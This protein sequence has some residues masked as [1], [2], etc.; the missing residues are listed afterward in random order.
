MRCEDVRELLGG[1]V[2]QALEPK[3][4]EAVRA[5]LSGCPGCAREWSLLEP[6]P[7]LLE[8]AHDPEVSQAKP[9]AS[10]EEAVLDRFARERPPLRADG[11]DRRGGGERRGRGRGARAL[12]QLGRP[13]PAA[14]LAAVAGAAIALGAGA[15]LDGS[16]D[17]Q[18]KVYG[19][20]LE[21]APATPG[22][23][24][25]YAY[26]RL[27]TFDAGTRVQL[28]V[29]G[30]RPKPGTVYELWCVYPDGSKVS[31]GTFRVGADGRA[32]LSMTTAAR[33]GDYH[34]LSVEQRAPGSRGR[35][36]M[37]GDI[38]Y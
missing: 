13:V 32:E 31:G 27:S 28:K 37:A 17:P 21:G 25:P 18:T 15:A 1:Y 29:S 11:R 36:V 8:A 9:P 19:A 2:L 30:L 20:H 22:G 7:E 6:L 24:K 26:A 10:L 5:H 14:A 33:V 23:P 3:E 4:S 34:R 35:A 12:R 16:D 38:A